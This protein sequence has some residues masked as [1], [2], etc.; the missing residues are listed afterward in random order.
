MT[1]VMNDKATRDSFYF[2]TDHHWTPLAASIAVDETLTT[3]NDIGLNVDPNPVPLVPHDAPYPFY[4]SGGRTATRGAGIDAD[5]FT[6]LAPADGFHSRVC[7]GS[8]CDQVPFNTS[9][10]DGTNRYANQYTAYDPGAVQ[11]SHVHNDD[12]SASPVTI[13]VLHDSYGI[14]YG[15][16]LAE[17]VRDVYLFDER[18]FRTETLNQLIDRIQ[19]DAIVVMHSTQV[20]VT[21]HV[22]SDY[23]WSTLGTDEGVR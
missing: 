2:R 22:W 18:Y 16:L 20:Y 10:L 5:T 1:D 6:W 7:D 21:S 23:L 14:P 13:L 19:P 11:N 3:L 15:T 12:A 4:G 8:T 17:N 9:I